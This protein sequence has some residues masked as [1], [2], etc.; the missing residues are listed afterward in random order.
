M[1]KISSPDGLTGGDLL[2]DGALY[3]PNAKGPVQDAIMPTYMSKSR[4]ASTTEHTT[5]AKELL[6]ATTS[7]QVMRIANR[8][9]IS[10]VCS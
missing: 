8:N 1:P 5:G 4:V 6:D 9:E 7:T 10:S 2:A 3:A